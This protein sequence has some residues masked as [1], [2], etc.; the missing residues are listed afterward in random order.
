[1]SKTTVSAPLLYKDPNRPYQYKE[2]PGVFLDV[3]FD[4]TPNTQTKM[5]TCMFNVY[6][7]STQNAFTNVIGSDTPENTL[8]VAFSYPSSPQAPGNPVI[9]DQQLAFEPTTWDEAF[10]VT[11]GQR[12]LVGYSSNFTVGFT[13]EYVG[14]LEHLVISYN[15][16]YQGAPYDS[17]VYVKYDEGIASKLLFERRTPDVSVLNF[18]NFTD[19]D[20]PV[21]SYSLSYTSGVTLTAKV[22]IGNWW[23]TRTIDNPKTNGTY[24][25]VMDAIEIATLY[26][27]TWNT[28]TATATV[29][30][31]A[32]TTYGSS[33][34]TGSSIFTINGGSP[35]LAPTYQI[36]STGSGGSSLIYGDNEITVNCNATFLKGAKA[37]TFRITCGNKVSSAS[38][39]TFTNVES[40]KITCTVTDSRGNSTTKSITITEFVDYIPLT[41][42]VESTNPIE[43]EDGSVTAKFNISGAIYTGQI[44][45]AA[46]TL[47]LQYRITRNGVEDTW[48]T[49][50]SS[51]IT[52][53]SN[54]YSAVVPVTFPKTDIILIDVKAQDN[55]K[56]VT[57]TSPTVTL[58]PVF[59]WSGTDFNFN[60]PI[61]LNGKLI[62]LITESGTFTSGTSTFYYRKWNDGVSE[63]WGHISGSVTI[64]SSSNFGGLYSS[65]EI[66][67]S[68]ITFPEGLF[69]DRP[70]VIA[71][72]ESRGTVA[73]LVASTTAASATQSGSY[74]I[75]QPSYSSYPS[76][77][78]CYQIRGRWKV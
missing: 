73:F 14:A 24:S 19:I 8:N 36:I 43:N 3:E 62:P 11:A 18:T 40:N 57:T 23:I 7:R 59:D 33:T 4:V 9:Y 63:A 28:N 20:N 34:A 52:I 29:T 58:T 71:Q 44:N 54:K 66:S 12:T 22:S 68:N 78:I 51:E 37:G 53:T 46:N 42:V 45:G 56:E 31:T 32:K 27:E 47:V 76:Y 30:L 2:I 60:V 39:A 65:E 67:A 69:I 64:P 15:T 55:V 49:K 70:D 74:Q 41:C 48:V 26:S 61:Y 72:L 21:V 35:Q 5:S 1:M 13:N 77:T 17:T 25:F 6:L 38:S 50:P 75:V 16:S 10:S